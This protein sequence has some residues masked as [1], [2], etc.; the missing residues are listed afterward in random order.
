MAT[1]VINELYEKYAKDLDGSISQKVLTFI[2]KL[3]ADP[4]V[5]GLDL[6]TPKGASSKNIKTARVDDNYRAVLIELKPAEQFALVCVKP[7]DDA[8][9]FAGK[10][11]LSVN[12]VSG[13]LEVS[14]HVAVAEAVQR[15]AESP[16]DATGGALGARGIKSKD[17]EKFGIPTAVAGAV[18]N[19]PDTDAL[20]EFVEVLPKNL[21]N[22]LLDL[23]DGRSLQEVWSDYVPETSESIDTEDIA[24][25][26]A[27]PASRLMFTDDSPAELQA[28]LEGS[29][30]RWRVWLHP[31][32]RA[33]A[34]HDGWN[35][36]ARVTGGAG[37][38][39]TVTAL[40]R[41]RHL[42]ERLAGRPA[43]EKVLVTTYTRNL[44]T[45]M[46]QQLIQLAGPSIKE[47]VD[48]INVDRLVHQT[49]SS[50]DGTDGFSL[51]GDTDHAVEAAVDAALPADGVFDRAFVIAE[52]STVVLAQGL[53]TRDEYLKASRAGRGRRLSRP[54]RAAVWQSI[55]HATQILNQQQKMTFTQAAARAARLLMDHSLP[56]G[57]IYRH[58]VVDE[59][60]D[61]HPA[62]WRLIRALVP[63][64]Q[65]DIFIAGDAHQRIYGSA[66]RLSWYGINIR[67]RSRR[68]TINYRT[69][70][71]ILAWCIGITRGEPVDDLDGESETLEGARSE[72]SGPLPELAGYKSDGEETAALIE[73]LQ[74]WHAAA[75]AWGEMAVLCRL[76]ATVTHVQEALGGAGIPARVV[77]NRTDESQAGDQVHVMTMNRGKGLEFRAVA[78]VKASDG[79]IP[80]SFVA[81]LTGDEHETA[82]LR[83]RNLLYVAGSRARER[84]AVTWA[85][86]PSPILGV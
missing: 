66:F 29:F 10:L 72:F 75:I 45:L 23:A 22:V 42:A 86:K 6:K 69:S 27:S 31:T 12:E 14:D 19:L 7:H 26:A 84:L 51:V 3:Q 54:Q 83:E 11:K 1:V 68:L 65:D 13:A 82:L 79:V 63:E 58:V 59:A 39:K 21:Q 33:V 47:R 36:P 41:A 43:G 64:G 50:L 60:Q 35:G 71:Q 37:T 38:G 76:A 2:G 40:H 49:L 30:A 81:Q 16:A 52:W 46:Q 61:F 17:L 53:T 80:P 74:H 32:Q 18:M 70:R 20:L 78:M 48:V 55:D 28:A 67:G 15:I 25:A 9:T 24:A 44:A 77:D 34:Y 62:H 57:S 73:R 4:T 56:G 5:P 85:G 8:Y